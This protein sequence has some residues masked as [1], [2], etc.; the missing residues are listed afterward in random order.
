MCTE[1]PE[2]RIGN[3]TWSRA[4][5]RF[6]RGRCG[7]G[8]DQ[9]AAAHWFMPQFI[10][11]VMQKACMRACCCLHTCSDGS[12]GVGAGVSGA[13]VGAGVSA[14]ASRR[15]SI[16]HGDHDQ[17]ASHSFYASNSRKLSQCSAQNSGKRFNN[18][19]CSSRELIG[20]IWV[21]RLPGVGAGEGVGAGV[22]TG[23]GAG[24]TSTQ[25]AS[26][27]HSSE[28]CVHSCTFWFLTSK[29]FSAWL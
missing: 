28:S 20:S 3:F 21:D 22:V 26:D 19:L 8:T 12:P 29:M 17:S 5:R 15:S 4:R 2:K 27:W 1:P 9:S 10:M 14:T 11:F 7:K 16:S 6:R 23:V 24:V 18:D 13:G 25:S